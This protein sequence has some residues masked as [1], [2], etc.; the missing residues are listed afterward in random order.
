M[1]TEI[2]ENGDYITLEK[3]CT[4]CPPYYYQ[5]IEIYTRYNKNDNF[6]CSWYEYVPLPVE[7]KKEELI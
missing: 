2:L 4:W 1:T 6:I 3:E 7:H 5:I